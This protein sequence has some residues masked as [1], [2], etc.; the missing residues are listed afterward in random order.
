MVNGTTSDMGLNAVGST[1]ARNRGYHLS[2]HFSVDGRAL[3][4][5][6][7]ESASELWDVGAYR[8]GLI[9]ADTPKLT[10]DADGP[11]LI[12]AYPGRLPLGR[13]GHWEA[14]KLIG[15]ART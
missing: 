9:G 14:R 2:R 12:A 7:G 11:Y 10:Q 1:L 6:V 13:D 15:K 8:I 5:L 3:V 4:E